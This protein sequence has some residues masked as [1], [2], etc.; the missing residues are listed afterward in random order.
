MTARGASE[1]EMKAVRVP[2]SDTTWRSSAAVS[3]AVAGDPA[4]A[5]AAETRC[6]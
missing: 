1:F 5:A 3:P 4:E 2:K 6:S